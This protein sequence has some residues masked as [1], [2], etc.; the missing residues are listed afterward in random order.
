MCKEVIKLI[1]LGTPTKKNENDESVETFARSFPGSSFKKIRRTLESDVSGQ[2][3]VSI[4]SEFEKSTGSP[5]D[6][7]L[8]G[9]SP[10]NSARTLSTFDGGDE[11]ATREVKEKQQDGAKDTTKVD[12]HITQG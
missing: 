9:D 3:S 2:N 7:T 1:Q 6:K 4:S 12:D 10:A 8:S 11:E 5:D